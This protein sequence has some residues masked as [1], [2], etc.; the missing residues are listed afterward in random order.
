MKYNHPN[1]LV[2]ISASHIAGIFAWCMGLSW[3]ICKKELHFEAVLKERGEIYLLR[4]I[5][6]L[7]SR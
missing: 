3:K 7:I 2:T 5:L 1:A 6:F 4:S